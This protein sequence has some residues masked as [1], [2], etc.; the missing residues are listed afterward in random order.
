MQKLLMK[1]KSVNWKSL[2]SM[3]TDCKFLFH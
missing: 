1:I 3:P 2:H